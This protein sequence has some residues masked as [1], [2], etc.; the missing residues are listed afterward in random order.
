MR[1]FLLILALLTLASAIVVAQTYN[2]TVTTNSPTY[3]PGDTV[4]IQGKFTQ[5]GNPVGSAPIEIGIYGPGGWSTILIVSTKPDGTYSANYTLPSDATPG[6]YNVTA[7]SYLPVVVCNSTTFEV[8]SPPT[9]TTPPPTTTTTT[10]TTTTAPPPTTAPAPVGGLL[11]GGSNSSH[12][13]YYLLAAIVV[14]GALLYFGK[15]RVGHK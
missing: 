14:A 4:L 5:D 10:V 12:L 8:L 11:V 6:N 3:Y 7:C 13:K 1:R 9:T 15:V 2:L